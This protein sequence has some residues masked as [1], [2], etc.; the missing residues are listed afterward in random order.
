VRKRSSAELLP[1]TQRLLAEA[2]IILGKL[3]TRCAL[4]G[5]AGMALR[6]HSRATKDLDVYASP[7]GAGE[8]V[9]AFRRAGWEID[10]SLEPFLYRARPRWAKDEATGV[11][12]MFPY[13]PQDL[14]AIAT[15]SR[16]GGTSVLV[17][18]GL[19]LALTKVYSDQPRHEDDFKAM[20]R[21]G[22]FS[23]EGIRAVLQPRDKEGLATAERWF[24]E[25][26]PRKKYDGNRPS[27][28]R[29]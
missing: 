10:S 13:E 6:G 21:A 16:V 3:K 7:D 17:F 15:A 11:D 5:A 25:A 28:W 26:A 24:A 18:S 2:E 22:I 19:G 8:V 23:M 4:G 9:G 1:A 12:L 20:A 29:K 27:R 14:F